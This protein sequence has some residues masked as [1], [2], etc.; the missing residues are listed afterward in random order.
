M[1]PES[2]AAA[3]LLRRSVV[4]DAIF[5]QMT[6]GLV[7][8]DSQGNLLDMNPAAL[9]IH[10]LENIDPLRRHLD[11]LTDTF[12]IFDLEGNPLPTEEWPIGRAL[13]GE[14]FE[15]YDVRVVRT[16]TDRSWIGSYGGAP[17]LD[18][19]GN[20]ALAIVTL[21]DVTAEWEAEEELS[22]AKKQIE[23]ALTATEVGVWYWDVQQNRMIGDRNFLR[24]FGIDHEGRG[25]PLEKYISQIHDDDRDRVVKAVEDVLAKGGPYSEEYRVIL[26]GG[27]ERWILARGR[28][29]IDE[30]GRPTAF[31]GVAMDITERKR[32]ED[33]LRESEQ[34]FRAMADGLPFIVWVHDAEG[35]QQ[36]VNRTFAEFFGISTDEASGDAWRNLMHPDDAPGYLEE[37]LRCLREQQP[38]HATV[39]VKN[40]DGSWRAIES[41]GRPRFSESDAFCGFVGASVDVT[42][43]LETE[44]ALQRL[45]RNLENRVD[46]RTADLE[47]RNKELEHFAY[48]ASHDLREP[49][50]KIR[51]FGDL[52][53]EEAGD[54]LSGDAELYIQRMRSAAMRMDELLTDLLAFSRVTTHTRPFSLVRLD[55]VVAVVLEDFE[56]RIRELGATI[57]VQ[58]TGAIDADESQLRQLI[59]NL[60][61]NALTFHQEGVSPHIRVQA[62]IEEAEE[63]TAEERCRIEIE[64]N[65]IGFDE[66]YVDRIFQPFERLHGRSRYQGTGMG[67]AICRRIVQRHRGAISVQ[68]SPGKGSRF[69]VTLPA[70]S[71]E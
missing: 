15:R 30:D 69:V 31:P 21:R 29:E 32:A 58:A 5:N 18:V 25:L 19:D 61:D 55:E 6:E 11:S 49:L 35:K 51:A 37:F 10:G 17:V 70:R 8:F 9:A 22:H 63:G 59:A 47:E 12:E 56:L 3:D 50:R 16:D 4:I 14:T 23:T 45:N 62:Y 2:S 1:S 46:E 54:V 60:I 65:G 42:E 38:F 7:I 41:Y 13:R 57:D 20:L 24:L 71:P 33:A 39:R 53:Q 27:G 48:I 26:A 34:R 66:K 28:V 67:L 44:R 52:L 64:D 68:S 40:A 36:F 43:R